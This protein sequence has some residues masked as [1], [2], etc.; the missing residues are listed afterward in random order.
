MKKLP[1][2]ASMVFLST[3]LCAACD[4][5]DKV[6][7]KIENEGPPAVEHQKTSQKPQGEA[8]AMKTA[9]GLPVLSKLKTRDSVITIIGGP[10]GI[11]YTVNDSKGNVVVK[12]ALEDDLR[13]KLPGAYKYVK[14]TLAEQGW[15]G[16]D[17]KYSDPDE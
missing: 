17:S 15:A 6:E 13:V 4:K 14:E 3:A 1:N 16:L 8:N 12:E 2:L 5:L 11:L 9:S 10:N 7:V